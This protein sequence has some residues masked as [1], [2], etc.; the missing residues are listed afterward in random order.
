MARRQTSGVLS[1][2]MLL[3]GHRSEGNGSRAARRKTTSHSYTLS[4]EMLTAVMVIT[5]IYTAE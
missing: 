2:D 3:E 1:D 4:F 5:I